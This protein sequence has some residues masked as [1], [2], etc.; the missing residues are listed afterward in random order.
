M[1]LAH[2]IHICSLCVPQVAS[3]ALGIPTDM[4]HISETATDKVPNSSP[5]AASASSDLNGMAVLV[6]DGSLLP[7]LAKQLT[8]FVGCEEVLTMRRMKCACEWTD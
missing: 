6:S 8:T 7:R 4:I 3:R 5:T 2:D 1:L